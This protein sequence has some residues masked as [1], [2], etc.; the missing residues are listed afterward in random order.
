MAPSSYE[1]TQWTTPD[2]S[3]VNDWHW[4]ER[5]LEPSWGTY[6]QVSADGVILQ[7]DK[8]SSSANKRLLILMWRSCARQSWLMY[9][10]NKSVKWWIIARWRT[11]SADTITTDVNANAV[12]IIVDDAAMLPEQSNEEARWKEQN[13][14]W[15]IKKIHKDSWWGEASRILHNGSW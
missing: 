15:C 2:L 6:Q 1:H 13:L 7:P 4:L 3:S 8:T 5:I 9:P 10:L 14:E 12:S 11:T